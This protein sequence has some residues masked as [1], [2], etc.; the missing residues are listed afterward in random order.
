MTTAVVIRPRVSIAEYLATE[1]AAT[2]K[3]I[4][5]DGEV[6]SVE[7]MAGGTFDHGAIGANVIIALGVSL[8]GSR[9]QVVTSDVKV[10]VPRKEGFVYPDATVLCGRREMYPGTTDVLTNPSLIVEVLSEGTEKFDRGDKFEG[11]RTIPTLRHYIM[12]SS[13]RRL[14]EHYERAEGGAWTLRE[15]GPGTE[16]R[17]NA[18]DAVLAVD[19]LYRMALDDDAG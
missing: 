2:E 19:E 10:W 13:K 3:H 6:F 17:M 7:A 14:V 8:R 4:L 15:Y 11:Y 5:W 12:V 18:P 9:C 1:A 16:L